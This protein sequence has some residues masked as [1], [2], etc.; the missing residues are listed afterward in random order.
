MTA[1]EDAIWTGPL[2]ELD[3]NTLQ[4]LGLPISAFAETD[5]LK[6]S[7]TSDGSTVLMGSSG[8]WSASSGQYS[9]ITNNLVGSGPS[10][11]AGDGDVFAVGQGFILPD[12][13]SAAQIGLPDELGVSSS[14]APNDA[15]L[16][17]SGSLEFIPWATHL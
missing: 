2:L 10:A 16:N 14:F 9:P 12:G 1:L 3:V 13:T 7:S 15:A 17:D 11:M 4:V 6:L 5:G 8:F